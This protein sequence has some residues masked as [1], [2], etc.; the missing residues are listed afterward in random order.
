M[1]GLLCNRR[2]GLFIRNSVQLYLHLICPVMD[3][4]CLSG[5]LLL[6][7][8]SGSCRQIHEVFGIPFFADCN[9]ALTESFD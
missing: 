2:N 7:A 9:R 5:G 1:L 8:M 3:Y 6:V 4:A